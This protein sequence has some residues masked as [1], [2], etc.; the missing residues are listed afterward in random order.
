MKHNACCILL[1]IVLCVSAVSASNLL[2]NGDFEVIETPGLYQ[3]FVGWPSH[4]D[5]TTAATYPGVMPHGGAYYMS[6]R[7]A[8]QLAHNGAWIPA[9]Q[10]RVGLWARMWDPL[11]EVDYWTRA[12]RLRVVV[13]LDTGGYWDYWMLPEFPQ[14]QWVRIDY[15]VSASTRWRLG[16]GRTGDQGSLMGIDDVTVT[17]IVPEPCGLL[18]LAVGLVG[19]L[20]RIPEKTEHPPGT[21]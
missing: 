6:G 7:T 17:P 16:F 18:V 3:R 21:G 14:N 2:P 11:R 5:I 1:F 19:V 10:Y 20:R 9:G 8:L 4:W 12:D 13:M 15:D